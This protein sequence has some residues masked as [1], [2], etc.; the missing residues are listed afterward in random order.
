MS[1]TNSH[2]LAQEPATLNYLIRINNASEKGFN[3][4]GENIRNRGLMLIFKSYA[5]ERAEFAAE[6]RSLVEAKGADPAEGSGLPAATHRGWINIKA[7]MTI[8][9]PATERVVLA[10]V[11]RGERAARR[12]YERALEKPLHPST[13]EVVQQQ[14]DR[15]QAAGEQIRELR[16]RDGRRTVIR[17]F[18]SEVDADTAAG[19]LV[20]AGFHRDNI[21]AVAMAE[22]V[23]VYEGQAQ[24]HTTA[25]SAFAG[26]LFGGAVGLLIGLAALLSTELVPGAFMADMGLGEAAAVSLLGGLVSG[27]LFG[28]LTGA[29]IG[30]GIVQEDT[31]RYRESLERG[32]L[33]LMVS[34]DEDRADQASTIMREVNAGRWRVA[35]T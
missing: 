5:Q 12:A 9:Q 6:L 26:A 11:S 4:A 25:E 24:A 1:E 21:E 3:L 28:V 13:V 8:G 14:Y 30:A 7:A 10:E 17:L 35:G 22:A 34:T 16:G 19:A 29:L 23:D 27:L 32:A 33:L 31:F 2:K 15:L 20:D 18:D